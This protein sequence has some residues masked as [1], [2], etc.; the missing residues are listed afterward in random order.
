MLGRALSNVAVVEVV[1]IIPPSPTSNVIVY[2]LAVHFAVRTILAAKLPS[3]LMYAWSLSSTL[4]AEGV[5]PLYLVADQ[6]ANV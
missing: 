3:S 1:P 4:S 2:S 6:P 5:S